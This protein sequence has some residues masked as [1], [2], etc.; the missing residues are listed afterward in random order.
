MPPPGYRTTEPLLPSV[1]KGGN[2]SLIDFL[3]GGDGAAGLL[4]NIT[5]AANAFQ[6]IRDVVNKTTNTPAPNAPVDDSQLGGS[7]GFNIM[8]ALPESVRNRIY[9][10][11]ENDYV[12]SINRRFNGDNQLIKYGVPVAL[13]LTAF[14]V[15]KRLKLF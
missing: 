10:D 15:A 1:R 5:G 8:D 2:E 13:S 6:N 12:A 7:G 11:A 3:S 4:E 9:S 14:I